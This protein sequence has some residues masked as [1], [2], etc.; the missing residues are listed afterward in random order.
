MNFAQLWWS[1]GRKFFFETTALQVRN[2]YPLSYEISKF[3]NILK[4]VP[5]AFLLPVAPRW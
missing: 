1:V 3:S 2:K 4:Y 5:K